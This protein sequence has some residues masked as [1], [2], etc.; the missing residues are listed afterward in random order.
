M[1][2]DMIEE[3]FNFR[4]HVKYRAW[5][6]FGNNGNLI[7]SLLKRRFWWVVNE[8]KLL[9]SNFVWT[10]LKNNDYFSKQ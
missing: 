9:E 2:K 5:I 7:K 10:Q 8:G 1:E 4:N 6:G 3:A